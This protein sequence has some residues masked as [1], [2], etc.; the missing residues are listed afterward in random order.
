MKTSISS[1]SRLFTVAAIGATCLAAPVALQADSLADLLRSKL[2]QKLDDG[3]SKES[4]SHR[5]HQHDD[6]RGRDDRRGPDRDRDDRYRAYASQPRSTFILSFGTGYAGQGYYY[7]PPNASY[8][9]QTPGVA[10]YRSK[11][12]VP[13]EYRPRQWGSPESGSTDAAVQRALSRRGYYDGPADGTIGPGTRRAISRY[14]ADNGLR[15]TGQIDSVLL[16]SLGM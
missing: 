16:R 1:F 14:Q 4:D 13:R 5:G 15:P 8:H 12:A 3:K 6:D 10:Y 2:R 11:E 7:G 9:Y